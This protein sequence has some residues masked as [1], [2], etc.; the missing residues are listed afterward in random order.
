MDVALALTSAFANPE[1]AEPVKHAILVAWAYA[2][3]ISDVRILLNG[4]KVSLIKSDVQWHTDLKHLGDTLNTSEKNTEQ[5]GLSYG[6]YLQL[7]LWTMS[8]EKIS[9][10]SINLIEQNTG[11]CMNQM[12]GKIKC[13]V[14]Y[15]AQPLFWNLVQL[16]NHD[17]GSYHFWENSEIRYAESKE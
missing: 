16:G 2:E 7:L 4:G 17:I 14:E 15:E 3:S 12:V 9:Q 1:L 11:V 6:G 10:R 5:E 8:N 13:S